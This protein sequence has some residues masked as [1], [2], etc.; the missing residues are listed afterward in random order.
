MHVH[1]RIALLAVTTLVI[2]LMQALFAAEGSVPRTVIIVDPRHP[3]ASPVV[4]SRLCGASPRCEN[5]NERINL[6]ELVSGVPPAAA[7][8]ATVLT[9]EQCAPDGYGISHCL[10]ALR[11]SD[12][13]RIVVRHSHNMSRYPCLTPGETVRVTKSP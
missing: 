4:Q 9:D 11:L 13:S 10:N 3:S 1:R 8:A 5:G 6:V 12:G 7:A 2:G